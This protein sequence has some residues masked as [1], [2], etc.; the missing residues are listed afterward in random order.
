MDSLSI[1]RVET[2]LG[3]VESV[4]R[5]VVGCA[6][7]IQFHVSLRI[8]HSTVNSVLILYPDLYLRLPRIQPKGYP[9][10]RWRLP[11]ASA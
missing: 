1:R 11:V 5:G 7:D 8:I 6:S 3:K 10:P 4:I 2:G 9:K